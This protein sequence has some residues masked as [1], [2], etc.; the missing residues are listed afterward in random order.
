MAWI[1]PKTNWVAADVPTKDDF[2]RIEGNIANIAPAYSSG[3]VSYTDTIAALAT[4]TKTIPIGAN[5]RQGR[6]FVRRASVFGPMGVSV[7]FTTSQTGSI[8]IGYDNTVG[9]MY[10]TA[11]IG[12]VAEGDFILGEDTEYL[13]MQNAY[14]SGTNLVII[15]ENGDQSTA[16]ALNAR[17]DW[18]VW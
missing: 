18:E 13:R 9:F 3:I 8:G 7:F 16:K 12:S 4:I 17:V 14:I 5:K 1:T 11:W 15:F 10:L 2:N 6:L